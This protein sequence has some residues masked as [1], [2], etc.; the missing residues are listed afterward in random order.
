MNVTDPIDVY[1]AELVRRSAGR[2]DRGRRALAE[3]EDH[4][5]E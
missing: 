2:T 1:L 5:R 3:M 4:L